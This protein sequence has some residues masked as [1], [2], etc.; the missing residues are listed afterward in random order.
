MGS[1]FSK[2]K[3]QAK[4]LEEKFQVMQEDLKKKE[5]IGSAA[6]GLVTITLSGDHK[7]KK[8]EIKPE[9]LQDAEGLQDLIIT[10]YNKA[11]EQL[12]TEDQSLSMM[13]SGM[14]FSF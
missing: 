12:E 14:P 11:S 2:M 1:G 10:A 6:N 5:V 4:M 7:M 9:C 8:I 13:K 3:K